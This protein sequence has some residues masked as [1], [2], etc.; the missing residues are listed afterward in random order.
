MGLFVARRLILQKALPAIPFW[1]LNLYRRRAFTIA[2]R[3][4][5][6]LSLRI[7]AEIRSVHS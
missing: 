4:I 6:F 5:V 2:D 1:L 7:V 3:R